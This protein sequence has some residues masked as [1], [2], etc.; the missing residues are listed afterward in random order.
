MCLFINTLEVIMLLCLMLVKSNLDIVYE[1]K[2]RET[3]R[4]SRL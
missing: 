4:E 1:E 2:L 3:K